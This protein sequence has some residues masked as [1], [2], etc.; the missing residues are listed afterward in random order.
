M[1]IRERNPSQASY[2]CMS[3]PVPRQP[4]PTPALCHIILSAQGVVHCGTSAAGVFEVLGWNPEPCSC[5][6]STVL[7]VLSPHGHSSPTPRIEFYLQTPWSSPLSPKNTG[8]K[9]AA[10]WESAGLRGK[11]PRF[12]PQSWGPP[13]EGASKNLIYAKN[14]SLLHWILAYMHFA[15]SFLYEKNLSLM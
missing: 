7:R 9:G 14:Q 15:I 12:Y 11:G 6:T 13:G 1:D 4:S 8:T 2:L 10:E 5:H 3:V